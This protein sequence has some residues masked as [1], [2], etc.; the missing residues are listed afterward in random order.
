[1]VGREMTFALGVD[2]GGT[3]TDAVA[4]RDTG[5]IFIGKSDTTSHD[6]SNGVLD[7]LSDLVSNARVSLPDLLRQTMFFGHGTTVGTNA[8]ITKRGAKVGVI[9]TKGFEDTPFI[10]RAV[11]RL[12]GLSETQIK[13]QVALRQ[14]RFL[15]PRKLV[16]GVTERI[17]CFGE[18]VV[19]LDKNEAARIVEELVAARVEAIAICLLGSF[20]NPLHEQEVK[21]IVCAAAPGLMVTTSSELIPKIRE[22]ARLN[23]TVIDCYVGKRVEHYL[24]RLAERL[25]GFGVSTRVNVMQMFG[26]LTDIDNADSQGLS[27]RR[28]AQGAAAGTVPHTQVSPAMRR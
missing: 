9:V 24:Q 19:P 28:R 3:F 5:E 12:A 7:A 4:I 26:G 13:N 20:A 16:M 21:Q 10:Q 25:T 14:P 2:I 18:I 17:D 1:M 6:F 8:L 23:S 27:R 22:N 11:G 15:V